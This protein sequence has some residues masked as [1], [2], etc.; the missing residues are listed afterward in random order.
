MKDKKTKYDKFM[1]SWGSIIL[2]TIVTT[3]TY[4]FGFGKMFIIFNIKGRLLIWI[5]IWLVSIGMASL[6]IKFKRC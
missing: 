2:G 6:V 4:L 5:F 1:E 3:L